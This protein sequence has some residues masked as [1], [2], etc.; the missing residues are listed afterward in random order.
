MDNDVVHVVNKRNVMRY[1]SRRNGQGDQVMIRILLNGVPNQDIQN[2]MLLSNSGTEIRN[3][4][5]IGFKRVEFPFWG[6]ITYST[7]NNTM[8]SRFDVIFE[9]EITQPGFWEI[10]LHH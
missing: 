4:Q 1:T 7:R 2:L 6:K 5:F 3:N 10:I 9:F 8:T